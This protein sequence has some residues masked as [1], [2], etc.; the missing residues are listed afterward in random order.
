MFQ[1]SETEEKGEKI[2]SQYKATIKKRLS[3]E[4]FK[5]GEERGGERWGEKPG[6]AG[7][8]RELPRKNKTVELTLSSFAPGKQS[9]QSDADWK[10]GHWK[11]VTE[12]RQQHCDA[13]K[14]RMR[15]QPA[16]GL[17]SCPKAATCASPRE[18]R[19][20]APRLM[21][22]SAFPTGRK[23]CFSF[24]SALKKTLV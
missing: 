9:C 22:N 3:T 6:G 23:I 15:M 20:R 14:V 2:Q 18:S 12:Q 24:M 17:S 1:L 4:Q 7:V 21:S 13:E 5:C 10:Q 11:K 8:T 16:L 19:E